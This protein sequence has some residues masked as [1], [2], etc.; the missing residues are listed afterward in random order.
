MTFVG[1]LSYCHGVLMVYWHDTHPNVRDCGSIPHYWPLLNN[2]DLR[3]ALEFDRNK[4]AS[5]DQGVTFQCISKC[6]QCKAGSMKHGILLQIWIINVMSIDKLQR[7]LL[8][9]IFVQKTLPLKKGILIRSQINVNFAKL[10]Q[11]NPLSY[12]GL[13][14][15]FMPSKH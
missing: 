5:L 13:P 11:C 10:Y 2:S 1:T 12:H 3:L 15:I 7:L 9:D 8:I 14:R 6:G 4:Q